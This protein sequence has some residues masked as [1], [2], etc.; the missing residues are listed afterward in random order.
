M[1]STSD[2]LLLALIHSNERIK[3]PNYLKTFRKKYENAEK[4]QQKQNRT[5]LATILLERLIFFCASFAGEG[6]GSFCFHLDWKQFAY[7]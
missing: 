5:R 3:K 4:Q 2:K 1:H 7:K 6:A